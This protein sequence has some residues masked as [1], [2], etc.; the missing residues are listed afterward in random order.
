MAGAGEKYGRP[1]QARV[2]RGRPGAAG[3]GQQARGSRPGPGQRIVR[4]GQGRGGPMGA[5]PRAGQARA[6]TLGGGRRSAGEVGAGEEIAELGGSERS[7]DPSVATS[8]SARSW[9]R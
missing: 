3:Q 1:G 7:Q 6:E 5:G 2:G 9:L 4:A 8:P